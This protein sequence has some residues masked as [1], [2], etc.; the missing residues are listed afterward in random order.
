MKQIDKTLS[1][2]RDMFRLEICAPFSLQVDE[3][4]YEFQCLIKGYGSKQGMVIDK[5]WEKIAP[6]QKALGAMG[7]GYSC[8]DIE[9][10]EVEGFQEILD[11][12]GKSNA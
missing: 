9:T 4:I 10:A 1:K 5:Q 6:I 8:Y 7:F 2:L 12:W 3:K 11:D